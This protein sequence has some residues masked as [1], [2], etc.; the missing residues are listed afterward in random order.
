MWVLINSTEKRDLRFDIHLHK[1]LIGV[2]IRYK[3][4]N[5]QSKRQILK[6]YKIK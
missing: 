5:H 4:H 3:K 1:K 2:L 6:L